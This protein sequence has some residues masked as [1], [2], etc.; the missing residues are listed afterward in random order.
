MSKNQ[1]WQNAGPPSLSSL[2]P[3]PKT[4]N[5]SPTTLNYSTPPRLSTIIY[6]FLSSPLTPIKICPQGLKTR[7]MTARGG[8][9]SAQ[10]RGNRAKSFAKPCQGGTSSF[11]MFQTAILPPLPARSSRR[12]NWTL[13]GDEV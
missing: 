6:H 12:D 10:P 8:A 9:Q 3:Q 4:L 2:N 7:N 13:A 1:P 5:R 11:R